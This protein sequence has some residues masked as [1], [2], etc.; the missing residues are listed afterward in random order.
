M[1]VCNTDDHLRNHGFLLTPKGW[2]LSPAYDLNAEPNGVR[3]G[4]SLNVNEHDN[5]LDPD[6]ALEVAEFF[7]VKESVAHETIATVRSTVA[8]WRA[9]AKRAGIGRAEMEM[10]EPAFVLSNS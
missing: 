10:M 2:A 3:T 7:R 5:R 6:L 4:L 1:F 8:D 9:V